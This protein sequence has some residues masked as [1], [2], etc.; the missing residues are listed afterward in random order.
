MF[1]EHGLGNKGQLTTWSLQT[2][3]KENGERKKFAIFVSLLLSNDSKS[4]R[5][6]GREIGRRFLMKYS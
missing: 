3:S 4:I 5:L 6:P 1:L 2:K